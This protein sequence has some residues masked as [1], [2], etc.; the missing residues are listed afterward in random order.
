MPAQLLQRR[1]ACRRLGAERNALQRRRAPHPVQQARLLPGQ[2][3]PATLPHGIQDQEVPDSGRS[4]AQPRRDRFRVA[5]NGSANRARRHR[6]PPCSGAQPE[7]WHAYIFGSAPED[8]VRASTFR[9]RPSTSRSTRC[10]RRSGRKS[11]RATPSRSCSASSKPHRLFSLEAVGLL[12]R[13]ERVPPQVS[14]TD[15]PAVPD[16]AVQHERTP[17]PRTAPARSGSPPACSEGITTRGTSIPARA[18]YAAAAPARVAGGRQRD[19]V[20]AE[21][22]RTC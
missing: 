15:L 12:Q 8:P 20:D 9:Q 5:G 3:R 10:R 16:V 4:N 19:A 6:T 2:H 18:A 22:F 13:R 7:L 17:A 21:L 11:R 14:A 1:Q